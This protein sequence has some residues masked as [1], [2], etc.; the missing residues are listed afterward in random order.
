MKLDWE[1]SC[2]ETHSK[3][4]WNVKDW[5]HSRQET[6]AI[7]RISAFKV[8]DRRY[9]EYLISGMSAALNLVYL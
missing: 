6:R 9:Y 5:G 3:V 8:V 7:I 1:H 4:G 2:Q